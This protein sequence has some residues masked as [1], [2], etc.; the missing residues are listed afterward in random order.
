[1]ERQPI[2]SDFGPPRYRA[3][4]GGLVCQPAWRTALRAFPDHVTEAGGASVTAQEGP[5]GV[6][7]GSE[8]T[9]LGVALP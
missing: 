4:S 1:M 5:S 7:L 2:T 3:S 8:A 6:A 9:E